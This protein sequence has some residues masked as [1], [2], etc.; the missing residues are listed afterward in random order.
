MCSLELSCKPIP[1]P[2]PLYNALL[3]KERKG[4]GYIL[5][6]SSVNRDNDKRKEMF[7]YVF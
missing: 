1:H 6:S 3:D 2:H 5:L 4:L 7:L